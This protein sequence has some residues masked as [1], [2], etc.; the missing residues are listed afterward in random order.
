MSAHRKWTFQLQRH[1]SL[2]LQRERIKEEIKRKRDRER[3]IEIKRKGTERDT[4]RQR[5]T[6]G[7]ETVR[8]PEK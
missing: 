1:W 5:D 4:E 6:K 7:I 2:N 3:M 8:E